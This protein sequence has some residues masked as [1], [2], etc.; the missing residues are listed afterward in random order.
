MNIQA[1]IDRIRLWKR[2][3][4][5]F[6]KD[7]FGATPD[8]WQKQALDAFV[9]DDPQSQRIALRACAGPGK[10]TAM[11]WMGWLFISCYAEKGEHPKAACMSI[12]SDNLKDNMWSEFSK[13]QGKSEFLMSQFTHT[14][15]RIFQNDNQ[16]TWFMSAR[17]FPKTANADEQ[18]RTL[19]G[20]HSK[21][22]LYL[23]DESGDISSNVLKAA[24]QGLATGPTFGKIVQAGNPTSHTG[25][26]Y[27]VCTTQADKWHIITITGDPDDANR[28]PR[29]DIQW[30]R[31]QIKQHGRDNPWVMAYILGL[32]PPGGLNALL[33]PDEVNVAMNRFLTIDQ[34]EFSQK[35][36][37]VD[38]ARFGDDETVLFPR[39]GLLAHPCVVMKGARTDE[40]S[41]RIMLAR[42]NWDHELDFVDGTGGWGAG[43]IDQ[44]IQ[45]KRSPIEVNFA[46]KASDAR[47]AN[48]RAEMWFNMAEW[49]KKRGVLPKDSVLLKELVSPTYS[50]VNGR[51]QLE[52]K[53]QI[54]KRLGFSPDR[55]DALALT[56]AHPEAPSRYKH[57]LI[58]SDGHNR[59]ATDY[60]PYASERIR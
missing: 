4:S 38:V 44:L 16:K 50:L 9:S 18:G 7:N 49:V 34:Y 19:S 31:D 29:I 12:T 56:F 1:S 6:V 11:V 40:I 43:V 27:D 10:S 14:S 24:E 57:P 51:F 60:D 35:R 47:Y 25:M 45:A 23:I 39:Q 13:W 53:E 37:G 15:E 2:D 48:K 54:K 21:Y 32:F 46:G 59:C 3:P 8:A 28:S 52:P 5:Q 22:I 20:L 26:L 33:G 36:L 41:A 58:K 30:A 55:A 17:S 42:Q